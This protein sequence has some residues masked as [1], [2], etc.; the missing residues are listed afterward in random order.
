MDLLGPQ[1]TMREQALPQMR[2]VS[3][4]VSVRRHTLVHL[5]DVHAGPWHLFVGEETQHGPR[6]ATPADGHNEAATRGHGRARLRGGERG[7]GSPRRT[8]TRPGAAFPA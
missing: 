6:R 7:T 2:E 4:G 1:R 3:I 8:G 5:D